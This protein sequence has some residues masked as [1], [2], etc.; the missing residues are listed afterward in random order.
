MNAKN[1]PT[2]CRMKNFQQIQ[3]ILDEDN[4]N[5]MM[6]RDIPRDSAT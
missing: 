6:T 4:K 1:N 5:L 3:F 2:Y